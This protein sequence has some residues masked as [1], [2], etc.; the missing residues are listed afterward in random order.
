[1]R[2]IWDSV[3][4]FSS[5]ILIQ[6][7]I[8][9][10]HILPH[11]LF[12]DTPSFILTYYLRILQQ[13]FLLIFLKFYFG[14][15]LRCPALRTGHLVHQHVDGQPSRVGHS[16]RTS[17]QQ[18]TLPHQTLGRW[19]KLPQRPTNHQMDQQ[20]HNLLFANSIRVMVN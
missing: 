20:S 2:G 1:M 18:T 11:I 9:H 17:E 19:T 15:W 10:D 6:K 8:I 16:R 5:M 14:F 12:S 3:N 4:L 13:T 7:N